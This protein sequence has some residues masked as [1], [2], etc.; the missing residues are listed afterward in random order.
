MSYKSVMQFLEATSQDK[1]LREELAQIMGVGDGDISTAR[2]LDEQEAKALLGHRGVLAASFAD[3][4]GYTFTVAELNSVIKVFQQYKTGQ[5][6]EADFSRALG[7]KDS[8]GDA[9]TQ[10]ES[11]GKTI[12]MVYLGVKY[13]IQKDQSSAHQ[14]LDFM[15]KTSED[16][17]FRD[18]LKN[19]LSV[20]DGDISDFSKLDA[21]ELEALRSERGALVAE[22]AATHGFSFTLADL[23]AVSDA[24]SRVK[25]GELTNDDFEKFLK[26]EVK[27]RDFFPFIENV[28]SMTY[29]GAKYSAPVASR[30]VDNTLPVVRFMERSGSDPALREQLMVIL[31]GDGDI[32]KPSELDAEE[33]SALGSELGKQIVEL[34]AQYGFR[35]SVADLSAVVGA[36]QLVNSGELP[37]DSCARILGLGKP[38]SALTGVKKTAGLIYRGVRY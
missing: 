32:S 24:F 28:V 30:A 22:F 17:E 25:A 14:V 31:G 1:Y 33:A 38:D 29:K 23:L 3:R 4:H 10:L 5:L 2:E 12:D 20:G 9:K 21:E 27:S 15:K 18:Q 36:F 11:V 35:F 19:I 37:M 8:S 16:P 6:S 7:L 13:A 26:L 34:G